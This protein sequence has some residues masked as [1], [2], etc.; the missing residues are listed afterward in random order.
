MLSYVLLLFIF[1]HNVF[2]KG[3]QSLRWSTTT[4]KC[5]FG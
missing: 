3:L 1:N 4:W 2:A 5:S